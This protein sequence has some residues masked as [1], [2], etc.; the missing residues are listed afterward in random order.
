MDSNR[1]SRFDDAGTTATLSR[2]EVSALGLDEATRR[3]SEQGGNPVPADPGNP[4]PGQRPGD[5]VPAERPGDPVPAE[6]P[7]DPVPP[8]RGDPVPAQRPG[9]PVPAE[10]PGDPVPA[11]R[12]LKGDPVACQGK[13][14]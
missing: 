11:E 12:P 9:D 6:R 13:P 1:M 5:P 8:R 7:G 3:H 2:E 14:R 4:V 10:R